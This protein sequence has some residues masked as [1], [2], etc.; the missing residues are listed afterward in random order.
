MGIK[1]IRFR[2]REQGIEKRVKAKR[3]VRQR[4]TGR[5]KRKSDIERDKHSISETIIKNE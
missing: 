5:K 3:K 2:E 4:K 1:S